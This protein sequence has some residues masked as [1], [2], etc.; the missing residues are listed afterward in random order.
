MIFTWTNQQYVAY[1]ATYRVFY[2]L[3]IL[4]ICLSETVATCK[5]TKKGK[6]YKGSLSQT[7]GGKTCQ[8][9]DSQTPHAH[10]DKSINSNHFPEATLSDAANYCRN[11]D[12]SGGGPWCYTS[13][14]KKKWDYC[15]VSYCN[16]CKYYYCNYRKYYYCSFKCLRKDNAACYVTSW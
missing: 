8:R 3:V 11:P 16:Y 6:E 10:F 5:A 14:P 4:N 1:M 9:W 12:S 15:D 2:Q 7:D 13:D